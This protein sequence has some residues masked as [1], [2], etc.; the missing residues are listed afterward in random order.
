MIKAQGDRRRN[1]LPDIEEMSATFKGTN[2][3]DDG[4]MVNHRSGSSSDERDEGELYGGDDDENWRGIPKVGLQDEEDDVTNEK[5]YFGAEEDNGSQG[6]DG[7]HPCK[8]VSISP[9]TR[10]DHFNVILALLYS[11][12]PLKKHLRDS[13]VESDPS[14]SDW[15]ET[16]NKK[17]ATRERRRTRGRD[18]S[19]TSLEDGEAEEEMMANITSEFRSRV[20][21]SARKPTKR[22]TAKQKGKQKAPVASSREEDNID[23]EVDANHSTSADGGKRCI[24]GPLSGEALKEIRK[25]GERTIRD[26]DA[27]AAKYR[28]STR[29]IMVAA[30]LGVQ[31]SRHGQNFANKFKVWYSQK[32]NPI[33]KGSQFLIF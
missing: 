6:D 24:P 33:R 13:P 20:G 9:L 23:E 3:A 25:L 29:T 15:A 14:D 10:V 27:L 31:H 8:F 11:P 5:F 16:R 2:Q 21:K 26:A 7:N 1:K 17:L 30:G 18:V 19:D 32:K 28:K 22:Y 12:Q 4:P